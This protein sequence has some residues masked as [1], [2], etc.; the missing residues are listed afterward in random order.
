M[1]L[2]IGCVGWLLAAAATATS[3]DFN[4][5][6][7]LERVEEDGPTATYRWLKR[8]QRQYSNQSTY[9]DWLSR[10]AMARGDYHRASAALET[11]IELE[12]LHLGARLDLVLALHMQGRGHEAR[13]RLAEFNMLIM[14]SNVPLPIEAARQVQQ[15]NQLLEIGEGAEPKRQWTGLV[16]AAVGYDSNANRAPAS[17]IEQTVVI[18]GFG[19][20]VFDNEL[21]QEDFY[22]DLGAHIEQGYRQEDCR[23]RSCLNVMAGV[24][25]RRYEEVTS[26]NQRQVYAGVQHVLG[27]RYQREYSLM[28]RHVR[29]SQLEFN[30]IDRQNILSMEYRQRLPWHPS[31]TGG[32]KLEIIDDR[33]VDEEAGWLASVTLGGLARPWQPWSPSTFARNG[34]RLRW[35]TGGSWHNRPGY[36]SGDSRRLWGTIIYPLAIKGEWQASAS[37]TYQYRFDEHPYFPWV[38]GDTK[39]RDHELTI[40]AQTGRQFG[41]LQLVARVQ[42]EKVFSTI[43]LFDIDRLQVS[44]NVV[45]ELF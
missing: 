20:V 11:L 14:L 16:T 5:Q 3:L 12:P 1:S 25:E 2:L 22:T 31:L 44:L 13:Q 40:G 7:L 24:F 36:T 8:S 29:S 4:E 30:Q 10:F 9:Y 15:L 37:A 19:S 43:E 18:P 38:F 28:L 23:I 33:S 34:Q 21:A 45:Y 17:K 27:G 26:Y 6:L 39:R 42:Y 32:A 35:E 41:S